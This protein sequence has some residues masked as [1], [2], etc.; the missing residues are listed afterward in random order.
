MVGRTCGVRN[1]LPASPAVIWPL[2]LAPK[3]YRT[4]WPALRSSAGE[5]GEI[6]GPR[7][8]LSPV[9]LAGTLRHRARVWLLPQAA[10][11]QGWGRVI[12]AKVSE[13]G[14]SIPS[15][16]YLFEPVPESAKQRTRCHSTCYPKQAKCDVVYKIMSPAPLNTFHTYPEALH[17]RSRLQSGG[18]PRSAPPLCRTNPA[19]LPPAAVPAGVRLQQRY[20]STISLVHESG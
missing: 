8:L 14:T 17:C 11:M 7:P 16:P 2:L 10:C 13:R 15:W 18:T 5:R 9:A 1:M 19:A 3:P 4:V 12:T 20:Q 6:P